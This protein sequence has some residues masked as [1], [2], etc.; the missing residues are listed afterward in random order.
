[1]M[2][3]FFLLT[4]P[5]INDNNKELKNEMSLLSLVILILIFIA[6]KIVRQSWLLKNCHNMM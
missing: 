4:L 5:D 2:F 3:K 6:V 1:M